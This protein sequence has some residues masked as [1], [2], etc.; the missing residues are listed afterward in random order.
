M[1]GANCESNCDVSC[2]QPG[3]ESTSIGAPRV[4]VRR[5]DDAA[6]ALDDH[7]GP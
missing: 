7:P 4:L 5:R 1:T 6:L 2:A 3:Q